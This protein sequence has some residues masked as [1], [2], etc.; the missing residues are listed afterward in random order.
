MRLNGS[1]S[2]ERLSRTRGLLGLGVG[3]PGITG[4]QASLIAHLRRPEVVMREIAVP[5]WAER[6][7]A[8]SRLQVT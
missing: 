5:D 7:I 2:A 6:S 1:N 8:L 3:P 4:P